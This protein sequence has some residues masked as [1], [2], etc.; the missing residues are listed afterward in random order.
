MGQMGALCE[1]AWNQG[2]DLYSYD[3]RR[4]LLDDKYIS[5]MCFSVAPRAEEVTTAPPAADS[6][7]SGS[8]R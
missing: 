4:L 7:S 2:D 6:T 3:G 8:A 1:M 5:Q